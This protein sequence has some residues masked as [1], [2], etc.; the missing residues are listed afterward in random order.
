VF[1]LLNIAGGLALALNSAYFGAWPS[2]VLNLVWI[3]IGGVTLIRTWGSPTPEP[4]AAS[5][6]RRP[7]DADRR[8]PSGSGSRAEIAA[9]SGAGATS[10]TYL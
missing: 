1:Q 8:E 4:A 5:A 3:A 6:A 7:G 10:G 2:A 9:G